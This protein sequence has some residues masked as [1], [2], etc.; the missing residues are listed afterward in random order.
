[1]VSLRGE[2]IV[3]RRRRAALAE[4]TGLPV[5]DP[6]HPDFEEAAA[7]AVR[8]LI[9]ATRDK[10][11]YPLIFVENKAYGFAR[12][13]LA[14]RDVGLRVSAAGVIGGIVS[15][16]MSSVRS[17]LSTTGTSLGAV[18][19]GGIVLMWLYFPSEERVRSASN[20]Y[21]ERLLEALDAGALK[22]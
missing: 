11:A 22:Q 14:V 4:A 17:E 9:S 2:G 19:A 8:R 5:Q 21:T 1:M 15:F 20:D 16:G 6:E 3:A 12:N 10:S 13:L 7:N 18:V